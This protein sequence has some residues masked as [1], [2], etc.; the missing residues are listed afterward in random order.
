MDLL[1]SEITEG[2]LH[3]LEVLDVLVLE[4]GEELHL[5]QPHRPGEQEVQ[6]LA[7]GGSGTEVLYL[8][9]LGAEG[10]VD[11][12]EEL[13]PGEVEGGDRGVD[14][15]DHGRP[16][17]RAGLQLIMNWYQINNVKTIIFYSS[18]KPW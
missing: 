17:N 14:H 7:V 18:N 15:V 16:G 11:P 4:V 8:G 2:D 13:V 10:A 5:P 9:E 12:G 3:Q 1:N 6:Q